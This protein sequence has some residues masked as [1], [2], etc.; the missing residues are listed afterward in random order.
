MKDVNIIDINHDKNIE[1][2][3]DS[4]NFGYYLWN[5]STSVLN[6]NEQKE[7]LKNM[8]FQFISYILF[9]LLKER[10]THHKTQNHI[11]RKW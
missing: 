7:N 1:L 3:T 4:R 8:Y 2:G 10:R 9:I 5:S 6:N 11:G